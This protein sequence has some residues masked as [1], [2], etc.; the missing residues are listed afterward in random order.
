[1]NAKVRSNSVFKKLTAVAMAAVIGISAGTSAGFVPWS[2]EAISEA[3]AAS[4]DIYFDAGTFSFNPTSKQ[5]YGWTSS[6]TDASVINGK[7]MTVPGTSTVASVTMTQDDTE[8]NMSNGS[9]GYIARGVESVVSGV[10][11]IQWSVKAWPINQNGAYVPTTVAGTQGIWETTTDSYNVAAPDWTESVW[12]GGTWDA[13]APS[14]F[15][16]NTYNPADS[17]ATNAAEDA[18]D[19]IGFYGR[20]YNS[21]SGAQSYALN[22]NDTTTKIPNASGMST[23]PLYVNTTENTVGYDAFFQ[24]QN[25]LPTIR[26]LSANAM[27]G[28]G[29]NDDNPYQ[30]WIHPDHTKKYT[31]YP[32]YAV[33][34]YVGWFWGQKALVQVYNSHPTMTGFQLLD[35][36]ATVDLDLDSL[37]A[38]AYD[39]ALADD[40]PAYRKAVYEYEGLVAV[41]PGSFSDCHDGHTVRLAELSG[42]TPGST[43]I[44]LN[45]FKA[46]YTDAA[47]LTNVTSDPSIY[48]KLYFGN[49]NYTTAGGTATARVAN[50][51]T[52]FD[53][54]FAAKYKWS[55]DNARLSV[56]IDSNDLNTSTPAITATTAVNGDATATNPGKIE[57]SATAS[58]KDTV[59]L[60][61]LVPNTAYILDTTVMNKTTN[62]AVGTTTSTVFVATAATMNKEVTVAVD[63]SSI[64]VGTSLV[65]YEVL[66]TSGG[67]VLSSHENIND[68]AQTVEVIDVPVVLV[69]EITG[70]VATN[71]AD[72]TTVLDK[73]ATAVIKDTV[74]FKDL[75]VGVD[76]KLLTSVV[77]KATGVKLVTDSSSTFSPIAATGTTVVTATVDTTNYAGK[78]L[79]VYEVLTDAAGAVLSRHENI[80]DAAQTVT[81]ADPAVPSIVSTVAT[82]AADG[83]KTV[84]AE[85]VVINDT[86][87]YAGCTVG[88]QYTLK[89][90]VV[91]KSS[92]LTVGTKE[93]TFTADATNTVVVPISVNAANY[94]GKKLVVF[95]TLYADTIVNPF[96]LVDTH[97]DI[98]DA[99]QTVDVAAEILIPDIT[100]TIATNAADGTDWLPVSATASIKD[101]ITYTELTANTLYTVRSTVV[102][103][104]T[105]TQLVTDYVSTFT[106][107]ATGEGTTNVIIPVNTTNYAGKTLVVYEKLYL[108]NNLVATHEDI[109]DVLQ[110]VWVKDA[111]VITLPTITRT[112][113]TSG[114]FYGNNYYYNYGYN[115]SV[116]KTVPQSTTAVITD[117][118]YYTGLENGKL[119]T[120]TATVY[121]KATGTI[122]TGITSPSYTF[123]ANN[124]LGYVDVAINFDSTKYAGKSLVV[125]ESITSNV[126]FATMRASLVAEGNSFTNYSATY[127]E[128]VKRVEQFIRDFNLTDAT[129]ATYVRNALSYNNAV[130]SFE[131]RDGIVG[132]LNYLPNVATTR[133]VELCWHKDLYDADQTVTVAGSSSTTWNNEQITQTIA[134]SV[135]GSKEVEASSSTVISDKVHYL[136]LTAGKTYTIK[137]S[138]VDK[139]TGAK[140]V[141][142]YTTTFIASDLQ[143]YT[144]VNIPVNTL[145]Y[146]GKQLVVFEVIYDG[147]TRVCAHEDLFDAGQTVT[148]KKTTVIPD[149]PDVPDVPD[150]PEIIIPDTS[151]AN[152]VAVD[153]V[154]KSH[155]MS[156]SVNAAIQHTVKYVGLVSGQTYTLTSTVYDKST[157]A[158]ILTPVSKSFVADSTNKVTNLIPVNTLQYPG[159]TFMVYATITQNGKEVASYKNPNDSNIQVT[160]ATI[161]TILTASNNTSKTVPI[162]P[163]VQVVDTVRYTGLT[164]GKTYRILGHILNREL[165]ADIDYTNVDLIINGNEGTAVTNGAKVIAT[166]TFE[167]VPETANGSINVTFYVNTS[168]LSGQH[169]VAFETITDKEYSTVIATEKN[170]NDQNQTVLV[171]MTTNVYTGGEDMTSTFA[172][173]S[174]AC[175]VAALGLCV[176]IFIKK[177]NFGSTR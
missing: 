25:T 96:S 83:T 141:T 84:D 74:S 13:A 98:N 171:K 112:I 115:Y 165:S 108:G 45:N 10:S 160:V 44:D 72:G 27:P 7:A 148:V 43:Y 36:K 63:A 66:K 4:G 123:T 166:Q 21:D 40:D 6:L 172:F 2:N 14:W 174:I 111:E 150:I 81:V 129:L 134:T 156:Y 8:V 3:H 114:T 68:A 91:E 88:E 169:L 120:V 92:G 144:T 55:D 64:A 80:N 9:Y 175:I 20:V 131:C 51:R 143:Q 57:A 119:Y 22:V 29:T 58:I 146:E 61:N 149:D 23:I 151:S 99:Q 167:F 38:A 70:T 173:G 135:A 153:S 159:K 53:I 41:A 77:D 26:D 24:S 42:L 33:D 18:Y 30:Y 104:T 28:D 34:E 126:T 69:P 124:A 132:I 97:D 17:S 93:K 16:V 117:R 47:G 67:D 54:K 85:E 12:G 138:V 137:S 78:S 59:A 113:A 130:L 5:A 125:F 101:A 1:M 82:N 142:D 154:N 89:A 79:V 94:A 76:Y 147:A 176:Y 106:S 32:M 122:V 139:T 110:T 145:A 103:K 177:R 46:T 164:P 52:S 71:N 90:T 100:K 62:A 163:S 75:T 50:S 73:S 102:D 128:W 127:V 170:I 107:S 19:D 37:R 162:G 152:A 95:E 168:N 105:R 86:V 140:L 31:N 109:N 157:G 15:E 48:T 136:Y 87:T 116:T 161:T 35:M 49:V 60:E 155:T 118:V 158:Q 121:D 133:N 11:T 56:T 39:N 65:I